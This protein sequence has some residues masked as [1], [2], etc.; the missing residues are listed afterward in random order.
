L[1]ILSNG[2]NPEIVDTQ[3]G[4]LFD[5][6]RNLKFHT[7]AGVQR[8]YRSATHMISNEGE[9][10]QFLPDKF[11]MAGAVEN[12]L[13]DLEK[14]MI[15]TLQ[16]ILIEAKNTADDWDRDGAKRDVWLEFY[17]A[18]ISLLATQIMW[19]EETEKAFDDLESGSE[20]A[21]KD[22]FQVILKRLNDLIIR[23]RDASLSKDL[24]NKI[25]TI[26]TID[27]Y[28]RDVIEKFLKD[29]ITDVGSFAWQKQLKFY[30]EKR[31]PKDEVKLCTAKICDW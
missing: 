24:R 15:T 25:I 21:M 17:C 18:Q 4:N 31:N 7:G 11:L 13:N 9:I 26:I 16:R 1:D 6:L 30:L 20:T 28:E 22:Y 2:N 3:V 19:T 10:V 27:V 29:K 5:G 23:V 12:Y 14:A 8:P